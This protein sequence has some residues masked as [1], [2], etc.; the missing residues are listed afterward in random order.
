MHKVKVC[1]GPVH[2]ACAHRVDHAGEGPE[3]AVDGLPLLEVATHRRD[4]T[5]T[6]LI[7]KLGARRR[8]KGCGHPWRFEA[9]YDDGTRVSWE[10]RSWSGPP[11]RGTAWKSGFSWVRQ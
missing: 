8:A 6:L 2:E 4:G 7:G 5:G 9:E 3:P 11:D 1:S 10:E